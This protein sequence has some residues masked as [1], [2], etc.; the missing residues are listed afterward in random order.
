MSRWSYPVTDGRRASLSGSNRHSRWLRSTTSEPGISPAAARCAAGRMSMSV[1]PSRISPSASSGVTRASR[2]R[3]AARISP[4]ANSLGAGHG[5]PAWGEVIPGHGGQR[6]RIGV[7]ADGDR[8]GRRVPHVVHV[9]RAER[10]DFT[11]YYPVYQG[12]G[13]AARH[14]ALVE[15]APHHAERPR[16]APV[17]VEPGRLSGQPADQPHFEAVLGCD[18]LVPSSLG[19]EPHPRHPLRRGGGKAVH[20]G[21]Q[22]LW[23]ENPLLSRAC[24]SHDKIMSSIL[25]KIN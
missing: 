15:R 8:G 3:A 13:P 2:A 12:S 6:W 14:N 11:R 21:G 23:S 22:L 17:V 4:I 19:V 5:Q 24:V 7:H 16:R 25:Y 1:A 20:P 18:A 10:A 9:A